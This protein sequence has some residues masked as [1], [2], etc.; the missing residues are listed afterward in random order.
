[1]WEGVLFLIYNFF[2]RINYLIKYPVYHK[3][4]KKNKKLKNIHKKER[5]FIVLNGPSINEHDLSG[6]KDEYVFVS[7]FFYRSDLCKIIEPNYYCW[8]D[9]ALM[10]SDEIKSVV[11]ELKCACPKSKLIFN[12]KACSK[13]GERDDT[14]YVYT[15]NMANVFGISNNLAGVMSNYT[16]VA[17]LA[18]VSAIYMGFSEIYILGLDFEP[19]GFS[20]FIHLG[21]NSDCLMPG[22]EIDKVKVAGSYRQYTLAQYQSFLVSE[23]AK[24]T[25]TK[26]VN[27]NPRSYI[28]A[29]QFG[30]Y[31]EIMDNHN[32]RR[33]E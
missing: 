23:L 14:Y 9:S 2:G 29:F 17:F 3:L 19:T 21:E 11:E 5:C 6:L 32:V 7:N 1:M 15:K 10:H 27:L 8:L 16:N 26:V 31:G 12:Y 22:N 4:L 30:S 28:R 13:L 25:N 33:S 20:H 18:I 24:K